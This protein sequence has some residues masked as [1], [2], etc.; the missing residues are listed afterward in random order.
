M[1]ENIQETTA[2]ENANENNSKQEVKTRWE[3]Q[4]GGFEEFKIAVDTLINWTNELSDK[5]LGEVFESKAKKSAP[6]SYQMLAILTHQSAG[7]VGDKFQKAKENALKKC[8][9]AGTQY[10]ER[11]T[12]TDFILDQLAPN[13]AELRAE[14]EKARLA[15]LNAWNTFVH[16]VLSAVESVED[17]WSEFD[18]NVSVETFRKMFPKYQQKENGLSIF[19]TLI[20]RNL[21]DEQEKTLMSEHAE[22]AEVY[23]VA[24][25]DMDNV[26]DDFQV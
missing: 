22:L 16:S 20:Y 21:N 13:L 15:R 26:P 19:K 9:E 1:S 17:T 12:I 4:L 5:T 2:T 11:E 18:I 25:D 14:K 7:Y 8:M 10:D 6:F 23:A 3:K 24:N